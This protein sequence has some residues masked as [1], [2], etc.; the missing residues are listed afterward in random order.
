MTNDENSD[1]DT[2]IATTMLLL[3]LH[4]IKV[5]KTTVQTVIQQL[6]TTTVARSASWLNVTH[7][8]RWCHVATSISESCANEVFRQGR[9]CPICRAGINMILRVD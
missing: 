6:S 9:G 2:T 7:A 4:K 5:K 3:L 1:D 8:S